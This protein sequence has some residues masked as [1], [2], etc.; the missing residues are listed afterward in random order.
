[1]SGSGSNLPVRITVEGGAQ[2]EAAFNRVAN[3][4]ERAMQTVTNS[5]AQAA[6]SGNNLRYVVGQAGYQVQDFAVQVQGG[7]SALTALSQQ[8]GQFL[9]IFGPAGAAA[10]AVLTIGLI[11]AQFLT[12]S[13]NAAEAERRADTAFRNMRTSAEDL[14]KVL[15][16]VNALFQTQGERATTAANETR[17]AMATRLRAQL[18]T[19][20]QMQEDSAAQLVTAQAELARMQSGM[21]TAAQGRLLMQQAAEERARR[22]GQPAP[23]APQIDVPN[24]ELFA[25]QSRISNLQAD[26]SR[27]QTAMA[28]AQ[29]ALNRLTAV[30]TTDAP[31]GADRDAA[32]ALRRSLDDRYRIN[33]EYEEKVADL[34]RRNAQG[35]LPDGEIG[36]LEVQAARRRDEALQRLDRTPNGGRVRA[37][38][39]EIDLEA[40]LAAMRRESTQ[41][42]DE[43]NTALNL[44]TAGLSAAQGALS[45]Y[46][47]DMQMLETALA[48]GVLTETEFTA[49]VEASTLAL[50]RQIEEVQRRGVNTDAL[51]REL[52]MTFSSAFEDAI[53]KGKSFSDVLKGIEQDIARIIIRQAVTAP[54]SS[55][56]SGAVK[57]ID[58]GA[59]AASLFPGRADGGPVSM[60]TTYLVGERGP[61][62]FTP[63][64]SGNITPNHAIG[65]EQRASDEGQAFAMTFN[66]ALKDASLKG[67]R[68]FDVLK[69][70]DQDITRIIPRQAVTA[71]L[72]NATIGA[73]KG[74]DLTSS[75]ANL[76][77]GKADGGPV[78]G[79]QTYLVG[80][81]GPELFTP[82]V[83][84]NITPNHAI[85]GEN[86]VT[87]SPTY[88]IDARNADASILPRV[89][90]IAELVSARSLA[91]FAD[92]IQRGGSAARLV[93]RR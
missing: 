62:L 49:A 25:L 41:S 89:R 36:S 87:F 16:E 40:V 80:E 64:A 76:F 2:A 27:S 45:R 58:F 50:G 21:G 56:I 29:E 51:G 11:A 4:G 23:E 67:K 32:E 54:L 38:Q 46:E 44:S 59:I 7:T 53:V 60:G 26:I 82:N 84:G 42:V 12:A 47:R 39:D 88:N 91:Q 63:N 18:D 6:S 10:G 77:I 83:S 20:L 72:T 57:N 34:R 13:D 68:F 33:Q 24:R 5:T 78:N 75:L 55:A 19:A 73:T 8:G 61:E 37:M 22:L 79:G 81:R 15:R 71:P 66:S 93:G 3:A 43:F 69:A 17:E 1:M 74:I 35:L 70:I 65:E 14:A 85:G 9:G 48:R 52:G 92:S 30:A 90:A 31:T 86:S 28:S